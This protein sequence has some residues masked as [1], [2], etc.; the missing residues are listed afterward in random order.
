[1]RMWI[2]FLFNFILPKLSLMVYIHVK[3]YP[4][5]DQTAKKYLKVTLGPWTL[6]I[7]INSFTELLL[8]WET[9]VGLK[10]T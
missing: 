5:P 3:N 10:V 7:D 9:L 1:M 8:K 4:K 6:I 2:D